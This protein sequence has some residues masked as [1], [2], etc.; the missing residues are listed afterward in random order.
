MTAP[1]ADAALLARAPSWV[2][3]ARGAAFLAALPDPA[4][5]QW[6]AKI[7]AT[8]WRWRDRLAARLDDIGIPVTV[9]SA[10]LVLAHVGERRG[11]DRTRGVPRQQD[12][13]AIAARL[14][15]A[16]VHVRDV[17]SFGLP[18][19]LRLS[20]QPPQAQDALVGALSAGN[21][22]RRVRRAAQAAGSRA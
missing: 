9:G 10:N 15:D 7:R 11:G 2:L 17:T 19:A 18:D 5:V 1:P 3:S 20:A 8:L 4:A 6:V 13:T 22:R 12:A 21:P 16:S 14:R